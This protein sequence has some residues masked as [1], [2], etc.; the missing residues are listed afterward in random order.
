MLFIATFDRLDQVFV[1]I[2]RVILDVPGQPKAL[3]LGIFLGMLQ[4]PE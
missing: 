2:E 1:E 4:Q 3:A